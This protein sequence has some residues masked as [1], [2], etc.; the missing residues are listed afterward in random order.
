MSDCIRTVCHQARQG[1]AH[2]SCTLDGRI[3]I[4]GAATGV[5][6]SRPSAP[7]SRPRRL[8]WNPPTGAR[9]PANC[10]RRPTR[11]GMCRAPAAVLLAQIGAPVV[12][13]TEARRR[14]DEEAL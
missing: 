8:L 10:R 2:P 7:N 12:F 1:F 4:H 9:R 11:R 5:K 14:T 6:G 13:L 3:V